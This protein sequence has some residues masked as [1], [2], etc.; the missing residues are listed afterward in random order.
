MSTRTIHC[1]CPLRSNWFLGQHRK[2]CFL[3]LWASF[4]LH[5][6]Q[7]LICFILYFQKSLLINVYVFFFEEMEVYPTLWYGSP[8]IYVGGCYGLKICEAQSSDVE[9]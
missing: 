8:D 1:S 5:R 3:P 6:S 2:N 9:P 4:W 7:F